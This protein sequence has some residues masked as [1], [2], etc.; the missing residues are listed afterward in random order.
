MIQATTRRQFLKGSA[1]LALSSFLTA[2]KEKSAALS[3]TTDSNTTGTLPLPLPPL[4]I[5]AL[6]RMAF[7]PRPGDIDRVRQI[8]FEVYVEEQLNPNDDDNPLFKERF[9]QTTLHI[10]YEGGESYDGVEEDRPLTALDKS[11]AE[12]WQLS[13][14]EFPTDYAERVRPG[15]EGI[16]A[17]WLRAVYSKWQLR[18]ILADFWHNHFNVNM[19]LSETLATIWPI[20]DRQVI[21]QHCLGNFRAFLEAVAQSQ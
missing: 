2:C 7:G 9:A 13:S 4:E 15:E 18:E 14:W 21:R 12:L 1:L 8:G 6:Q 17:T 5:I 11:L 10:A 3:G 20:Y 16:V 19:G